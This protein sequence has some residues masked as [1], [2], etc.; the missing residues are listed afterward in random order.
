MKDVHP[1]STARNDRE[2]S[3]HQC[4]GPVRKVQACLNKEKV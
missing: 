1:C 4:G 2:S 3:F